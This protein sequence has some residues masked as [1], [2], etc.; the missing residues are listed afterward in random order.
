[1]AA[2]TTDQL[3]TIAFETGLDASGALT[4]TTGWRWNNDTPATYLDGGS[5][6]KWGGGAAGT[7]ATISYYYD[8]GSNWTAAEQATFASAMALWAAVANVK[9][10][11]A[12][13]PA[14]ANAVFYRYGTTTTPAGL[15]LDKGEAY[16]KVTYGPGLPGDTTLPAMVCS[17][18]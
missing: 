3:A 17:R 12:A 18:P 1:M 6:H 9:F 13:T 4:T 2:L 8:S 14:A 10:V 11:Q 16:L 15:T 7:A 5:G